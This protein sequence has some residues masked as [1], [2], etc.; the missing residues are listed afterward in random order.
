M[1]ENLVR[2]LAS[3]YEVKQQ[4]KKQLVSLLEDQVKERKM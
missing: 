3:N 4:L 2:K 1:K